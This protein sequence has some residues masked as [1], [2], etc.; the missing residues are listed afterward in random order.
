MTAA[1][2]PSPGLMRRAASW[3]YLHPKA[4]LLLWLALPLCAGS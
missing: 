2:L 3:C 4:T 1:A